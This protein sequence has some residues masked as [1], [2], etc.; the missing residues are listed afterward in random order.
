MDIGAGGYVYMNGDAVKLQPPVA[1]TIYAHVPVETAM[2]A[3]TNLYG[4]TTQLAAPAATHIPLIAT[5]GPQPPH[6]QALQVA[7]APPPS[8]HPH[9]H[10]HTQLIQHTHPHAHTHSHSAAVAAAAAAAAV[11][12][13]HTQQPPSAGASLQTLPTATH[14]TAHLQYAH[15]QQTVAQVATGGPAVTTIDSSEYAAAV[16][17][18]TIAQDGSTVCYAQPE[19]LSGVAAGTNLIAVDVS[20]AGTPTSVGS[21]QTQPHSLGIS[22]GPHQHQSHQHLSNN[23]NSVENSGIPLDQLKQM[24]ST[25]LEYYFSRENLA[26]DTYLLTQMDSDQYVPIITVANFNLVKKL[27]KDIKL[28]T[29]VLRESPNVQVDEDGLRVRPNHKRCI[30]ILREISEKTPVEE[31]KNIF[32]NENCPRVIS[33][34]FAGNN[35]WY[36]TFESDEDAQKA[37]KYLREDVKMFKGKPIMARMKAKPFINRLP[38]APVA[39]LKNGFRITSPPA[40]VYDPNA[41]ATAVAYN[42]A[43]Q[44]FVYATNGAAMTQASVPYNAPVIFQSFQQQQFYPGIVATTPWPPAAAAVAAAATTAHGQNFYELG[45][46]FA[47]N[48]LTPQAAVPTAYTTSA[49]Q[50]SATPLPASSKGQ[51]G[52]GRYNNHRNNTS[53][54]G[55]G[56]RNKLRSNTAQQQQQQSQPLPGMIATLGNVVGSLVSVVPTIMDPHQQ[57]QQTQQQQNQ[58][59]QHQMQQQQTTSSQV[60][61]QQ[62]QVQQSQQQPQN[63]SRHYNSIKN[64]G[65]GINKSAM[66][67]PYGGGSSMSSHIHYGTQAQSSAGPSHHHASSQQQQQTNAVTAGSHNST[68][69]H[70]Q[71]PSATAAVAAATST[72]LQHSSFAHATPT[73]SVQQQHHHHQQQQPHLHGQHVADLQDDGGVL[74]MGASGELVQQQQQH[75]QQQSS[76]PHQQQQH[77]RSNLS[78]STS[79]LATS[80]SVGVGVVGKEPPMHWTQP[81]H[82]RRRRDDDGSVMT[83]TPS[84]RLGGGAG[85]SGGQQAYIGGNVSSHHQSQQQQQQQQQQLQTQ[86]SSNSGNTL[87]LSSNVGNNTAISSQS[88]GGGASVHHSQR[89]E[90]VHHGGGGSSYNSH[91]EEHRGGYKGNNYNPHYNSGGGMGHHSQHSGASHHH[92]HS[93]GGPSQQHHHHHSSSHHTGSTHHYH[94]HRHEVGGGGGGGSGGNGGLSG[95]GTNGAHGI[96]DRSNDRSGGH[97]HHGQQQQQQHVPP[98]QPPQFDLEAAAFPPLPATSSSTASSSLAS[99]G[100]ASS[101]SSGSNSN[102]VA[103][104]STKQSSNSTPHHHQHQQ[105]LQQQQPQQQPQQS[106]GGGG[107]DGSI[108]GSVDV[109]TQKTSYLQQQPQLQQHNQ[110]LSP[111]IAVQQSNSSSSAVTGVAANVSGGGSCSTG[112]VGS[113]YQNHSS[114]SGV[115]NSSGWSNE[116]RLADVVRSGANSGGNGKIKSR[117]DSAHNNKQQQQNYQQRN[118]G[119]CTTISPTTTTSINATEGAFPADEPNMSS[120]VTTTKPNNKSSTLNKQNSNAN[121]N[122]TTTASSS[123]NTVIKCPTQSKQT[124]AYSLTGGNA[125]FDSNTVTGEKPINK[126]EDLPASAATQEAACKQQQQQHANDNNGSNELHQQHNHRGSGCSGPNSTSGGAIKS[127][128]AVLSP[129][130]ATAGVFSGSGVGGGITSNNSASNNG[131]QAV[132]C[133]VATMT[134][135]FADCSLSNH[136]KPPAVADLLAKKATPKDATKHKNASTSTNTASIENIAAAQTGTPIAN[137]TSATNNNSSR[138]SYAQVAQHHKERAVGDG[139]N[140]SSENSASGNASPVAVP[141][142]SELSASTMNI[143]KYETANNISGAGGVVNAVIGAATATATVATVPSSS[144]AAAVALQYV[145]KQS[146]KPIGFDKQRVITTVGQALTSAATGTTATGNNSGSGGGGNNTGAVINSASNVVTLRAEISKDKDA[147]RENRQS[148]GSNNSGS[149]G[150]SS[151][152]V[153]SNNA[154]TQSTLSTSARNRNND[155]KEKNVRERHDTAESSSSGRKSGRN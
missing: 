22:N 105:P 133:S 109:P 25:Q 41:A 23:T 103:V 117:K 129:T 4:P 51:S 43:P 50:Q 97:G 67:K 70:Y 28:I 40:A 63:T 111:S 42:T 3:T 107:N 62:Q 6:P 119:A 12:G 141:N 30:I 65:G 83:Y 113:N 9:Q 20:M 29:E 91:R 57:Q 144:A 18:G 121:T 32:N 104:S 114:A 31:V 87:Q 99:T 130:P 123:N 58:Q 45:N 131:Q 81:R 135:N 101:N 56:G 80:S 96:S 115:A 110:C 86:Q 151:S 48:G 59:P 150:F 61:Q 75:Q 46:V 44:R 19:E 49:P 124:N 2:L 88:S 38:I 82:R 27:T 73:V 79:S 118:T 89:G 10:Q 14:Q 125:S 146:D 112:S 145:E 136:K 142:K 68:Q 147:L 126:T 122:Y 128:N 132:T 140:K 7:A 100:A 154:A 39:P 15:Q 34:E 153:L 60:Q 8:Q 13:P 55:G 26:N 33:C 139:G 37:F 5:T 92:H 134:T 11:A 155:G 77:S 64:S 149:S 85:V 17:N 148:T 102:N 36:I 127:A 72:N 52:G 116:N 138:L 47:T 71:L 108:S 24:L 54:A 78:S 93:G 90:S 143:N 94:H 98:P 95:G 106:Y 21:H 137:A 66:D 53:S 69:N 76:H 1:N 74:S 35:S 84:T 120:A 152:G 16:M